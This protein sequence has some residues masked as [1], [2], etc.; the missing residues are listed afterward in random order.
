MVLESLEEIP[1]IIQNS[2]DILKKYTPATL[3]VEYINVNYQEDTL[4]DDSQHMQLKC[5]NLPYP[6]S[7]TPVIC[8]QIKDAQILY[9]GPI[10]S[11]IFIE[12]TIDYGNE[13]DYRFN[14]G[15]TIGI[16]VSNSVNDIEKVLSKI[17]SVDT[18]EAICDIS[19]KNGTAKKN[20][21]LPQHVPIQS[22]PRAILRDCL[23]LRSVPKKLF[24]RSLAEYTAD[25][26]EKSVLLMLSSKEGTKL[27]NELI[28]EK[29]RTFLD[30]LD[31]FPS[32]IPTLSLLIEHLP[33]LKPRPYSIANSPL[34]DPSKVKLILSVLIE[35]SGV[36]TSFL[37]EKVT[38]FLE[39][40]EKTQQ[41][42]FYFRE[43]NQF[44]FDYE[45]DS[46]LI[47]IGCGISPF[48]GFLEHKDELM[49]EKTTKL[50][51]TWLFVGSTCQDSAVHR[52]ELLDYQITGVLDHL[53]ESF[54]RDPDPECGE[55][56]HVQDQLR[57][58]ALEVVEQLTKKDTNLYVCADGTKI[59]K[60]IEECIK[61]CLMMSLECSDEE[62]ILVIKEMRSAGRYKED[63]WV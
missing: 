21:K 8:G 20:P 57:I 14:P 50:G 36:A 10:G 44:R 25:K 55:F 3:P 28:L 19:I 24:L 49:K 61:E 32:C 17:L 58:N 5:S 45:K 34:S 15:D 47:G 63:I 54:S 52:D 9:D 33:R 12:L 11:K 23:D 56:K 43:S 22:S 30:I 27:Y 59:S 48:L 7:A 35:N 1:K 13:I 2:A 6:F 42:S 60:S 18:P 26:D 40:P 37:T 39:N 53:Y 16:L 62:A 41:L 51:S 38:S 46:I 29:T 4:Q 31:L